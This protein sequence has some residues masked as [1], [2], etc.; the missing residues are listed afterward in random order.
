MWGKSLPPDRKDT[1]IEDSCSSVTN[2]AVKWIR[3]EMAGLL[4]H[5]GKE[6]LLDQQ[7]KQGHDMK[8]N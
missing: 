4:V 6:S 2:A 1:A 8:R 7:L 3:S 5:L